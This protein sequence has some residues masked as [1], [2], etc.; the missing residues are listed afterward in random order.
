METEPLSIFETQAAK[1]LSDLFDRKTDIE[2]LLIADTVAARLAGVSR[3]TWH[4]LRA[5][6]KLPPSI[7]L[8]RSVRWR[9]AEIVAWVAAGCPDAAT[10]AVME[11]QRRRRA[12]F[13]ALQTRPTRVT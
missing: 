5:A 12:G 13:A 8:G 1:K 4:C 7:N 11:D 10:W 6:G 3:T 2:P 9:H